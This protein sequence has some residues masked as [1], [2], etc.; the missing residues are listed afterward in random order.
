MLLAS[1]RISILVRETAPFPSQVFGDL[2][3]GMFHDVPVE[4]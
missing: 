4:P 1:G 3:Q 2:T